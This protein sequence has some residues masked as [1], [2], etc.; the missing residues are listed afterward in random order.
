VGRGGKNFPEDVTTIQETLNK[1]PPEQGGAKPKLVVDGKAGTNTNNAIQKF[2]IHH[3]GWSKADGKVD[4]FART[5][6]KMSELAGKPFRKPD[7]NLVEGMLAHLGLAFQFIMAAKAN[8]LSAITL[9]DSPDS[10]SV[11]SV[12]SRP[13]QMKL[14]NRHFE[15]DRYSPFEKRAKLQ[16]AL[17]LYDTMGQVFER[18]GGLWGPRAFAPDPTQDRAYAFTFAGGFSLGGQT[19]DG[20]R[21]DTIYF[22]TKSWAAM[23]VNDFSA[24][25]IVHELAHFVGKSGIH[26]ILDY[27][28]GSAESLQKL[29]VYQKLLNADSYAN[30]AREARF[31]IRPK[32]DWQKE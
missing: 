24:H 29:P 4:P 27:G 2:Q 21:L 26:G 18:P 30:F 6:L 11:I 9:V 8:L 20:I 10:P 23:E 28:Y 15:I 19:Q 7:G 1:I 25:I 17:A 22:C 31:G 14:A 13:E 5:H 3:F 16:K 12:F 32:P